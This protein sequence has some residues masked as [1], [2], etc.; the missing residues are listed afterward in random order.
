MSE[1]EGSHIHRPCSLEERHWDLFIELNVV[2]LDVNVK[3]IVTDDVMA[4]V[5]RTH[6][7]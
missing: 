1:E 5:E 2:E 4:K 3:E 6:G 7:K